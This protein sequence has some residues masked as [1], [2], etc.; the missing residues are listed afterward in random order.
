MFMGPRSVDKILSFFKV[1][2]APEMNAKRLM[3]LKRFRDYTMQN[4]HSTKMSD[5]LMKM[6]QNRGKQKYRYSCS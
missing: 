2:I 6:S 4:H 3:K 1:K 5:E